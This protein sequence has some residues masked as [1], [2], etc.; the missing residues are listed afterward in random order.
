MSLEM[1]SLLLR[2]EGYAVHVARDAEAALLLIGEVH[3]HL[4]LV[5]MKLPGLDGVELIRRLKAEAT[6]PVIKIMALTASAMKGDREKALAAG[7]DGYITKPIDTRSF[8]AQVAN[9]LAGSPTTESAVTRQ[10]T[11][12][13]PPSADSH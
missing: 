12:E 8:P 13:D 10:P 9:C 6:V 3:P 4:V 11:A 2:L 1:V 5:D 7:C